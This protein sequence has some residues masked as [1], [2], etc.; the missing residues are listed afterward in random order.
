MRLTENSPGLGPPIRKPGCCRPRR[1][2]APRSP[3]GC[4]RARLSARI[5]GTRC[6]CCSA[7][8]RRPAAPRSAGRAPASRCAPKSKRTMRCTRSMPTKTVPPS[9]ASASVSYQRR[10][11]SGLP[12]APEDRRHLGIRDA[13]RTRALVDDAPAQPAPLVG[14]GKEARAVGADADRRDAAELPV[15]R[16]ERHPAAKGERAETRARGLARLERR[17][18]PRGDFD[19]RPA[20]PPGAGWSR[21]KPK[22]AQE[23]RK[24]SAATGEISAATLAI[25][26]GACFSENRYPLFRD[27]R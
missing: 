4:G 14:D 10:A 26:L 6:S 19:P 21:R 25:L 15:G 8:W 27:M 9:S 2:R 23:A 20:A 24:A 17:D 18:R 3:S 5:P 13:D 1:G 12:S 22:G 16:G 7:A 11:A